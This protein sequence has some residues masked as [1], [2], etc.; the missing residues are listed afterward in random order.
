MQGLARG[1]APRGRWK[2]S[3]LVNGA[4]SSLTA[5]SIL[6]ERLTQWQT[7]P[8][9]QGCALAQCSAD[10]SNVTAAGVIVYQSTAGWSRAHLGLVCT[11][12]VL[13]LLN[14]TSYLKLRALQSYAVLVS[15][16]AVLTISAETPDA[17]R[18][19]TTARYRIRCPREIIWTLKKKPKKHMPNLSHRQDLLPSPT[20]RTPLVRSET[21]AGRPGRHTLRARGR[22]I[23]RSDL[24][25]AFL[26]WL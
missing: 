6:E 21:C 15:V 23:L 22:F 13:F 1:L 7:A 17:G 12:D 10:G 20:L 8:A 19:F 16:V 18:H 9:S 5:A 2:L 26:L 11:A 24:A 14:M 25:R 4:D 3:C